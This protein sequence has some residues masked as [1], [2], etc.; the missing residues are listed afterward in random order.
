M[1]SPESMATAFY[2]MF[3]DFQKKQEKSKKALSGSDEKVVRKCVAALDGSDDWLAGAAAEKLGSMGKNIC[4]PGIQKALQTAE[5]SGYVLQGISQAHYHG[6]PE[7]G[8]RESV[9][10]LVMICA[11]PQHSDSSISREAGRLALTLNPA[12]ATRGILEATAFPESATLIDIHQTTRFNLPDDVLSLLG[13]ALLPHGEELRLGP[14]LDAIVTPAR[15]IKLAGW[16]RGIGIT[17]Y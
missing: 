3:R 15:R 1:K 10:P 7:P 17:N 14:F 9:Y 8:W 12:E 13:V 5:Y 11:T 16:P 4:L 2:S 6:T